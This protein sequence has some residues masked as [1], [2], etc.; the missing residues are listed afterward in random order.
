MT[1]NAAVGREPFEAVYVYQ[2]LCT[3]TYGQS[4]CTASL[5]TGGRKCF[6]TLPTCQDEANYE[7]GQLILRFCRNGVEV[8]QDGNYW[9]PYLQSVRVTAGAIN[10][11]GA[12]KNSSPLG[13]RAT[14]DCTFSDHP[15]SDRHVDPYRDERVTGAAQLDGEGYDPFSRSTFWSKWKARNGAYY[16]GRKLVYVSGYLKDGQIVDAI[17]RE[18][19]ITGFDGPDRRGVQIK[20]KD[21]LTKAASEKAKAPAFSSGKLAADIDDSVTSFSV[22]PG[23]GAEYDLSGYVRIG[24]EVMSYTRSG[25]TFTV[26]RAQW[27]TSAS[28]HGVGDRVQVC[29][30]FDAQRPDAIAFTLLNEYAG[31]DASSLDTDG[32]E[33]EINTYNTQLYTAL[34]TEP[35]A[36]EEL[37][38]ECCEQMY[39]FLWVDERESKVRMKC[40]RPADD[41]DDVHELDYRQHIVKDSLSISDATGEIITAVVVNFAMMNPA[42]DLEE[43][44]NYGAS[45]IILSPESDP[46]RLGESRTK[47]IYSRWLGPASGGGALDL[48]DYLLGRYASGPRKV[49]F[50]LDAKDREIWIGDFVR[51]MHPDHVDDEGN[52]LPLEMQVYSVT[53]QEAGHR[54]IYEGE[55]YSGEVLR[56][57]RVEISVDV[58]NLNLYDWFVAERGV[59]QVG[60]TVEITIRSGLTVSSNS[61]SSPAIASGVWPDGVVPLLRIE[62]N[63]YVVGRGGPGGSA[64]FLGGISNWHVTDGGAGGDAI[65]A[66]SPIQVDNRGVISGGGGGGGA[67]GGSIEVASGMFLPVACGGGGGGGFGMGGTAS[68]A[69]FNRDGNAGA[70]LVAGTGG[71]YSYGSV[72]V[73]GGHGAMLNPTGEMGTTNVPPPYSE[74]SAG[75]AAGRAVV[76]ASNVTWINKGDVRGAEV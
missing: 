55:I 5:A 3:R 56:T 26:A 75:G 39:F 44:S 2:D 43:P 12:D 68:G 33:A 41:N 16:L 37:L 34:I 29:L 66:E 40:V 28:S 53:E 15:H 23:Q 76:G 72:Y 24:D 65:V 10:P 45:Q 36:V 60:D 64:T 70:R 47:V 61:T 19:V 62:P 31:I 54:Y 25:D 22:E 14:I 27:N 17:E 57:K 59:P 11:G 20:G 35:T 51:I 50:A 71:S 38:A 6:N 1:E 9:L 7:K 4:P 67:A 49:K 52:L 42:R 32:W 74:T 18:F 30:H 8:P 48:G 46:S 13:R 63:T 69:Q 58:V 73:R 21:V